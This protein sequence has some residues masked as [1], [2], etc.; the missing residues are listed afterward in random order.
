MVERDEQRRGELFDELAK[1]GSL[2]VRNELVQSYAPL[3][4]F[5]AN[6]YKKRAGD[7]ND[8]RQVAHLALVKAVDRFDPAHGAA[9]S[10]FAGKTIDG[11]L[12]RHFRDRTWAVRVPRGLQENA[13]EVRNAADRFSTENGRAATVADLANDTGLS[14]D[15]V[16]EALDV[17]LAQQTSSLDE[18]LSADGSTASLSS[19]LASVDENF[20]HAELATTMRATMEHLDARDRTIIQLR[21]YDGLTQQQIADRL[22]ISQMHVS[23]L[24][25][26]ALLSLRPYLDRT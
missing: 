18:S 10:T 24:L 7:H 14:N 16:L 5:F 1:T 3:A 8:L 20:E 2:D 15:E 22:G 21:F 6:R 13:L 17:Q 25:R 11:E 9:F 19:K 23:R 12:K 26:G 4:E